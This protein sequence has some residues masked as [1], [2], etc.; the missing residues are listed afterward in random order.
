MTERPVSDA[1]FASLHELNARLAGLPNG[2]A[3]HLEG[4]YIG[5]D[6]L[7][8]FLPSQWGHP[9]VGTDSDFGWAEHRDNWIIER[10]RVREDG[11]ILLG[12]DPKTLI[13]PMP[14]DGLCDAM[15]GE[16]AARLRDWAA[17]PVGPDWLLPR[18]YQ[19]FEVETLSKPCRALVEPS[20]AWRADETEDASSL[21]EVVEF[22][23]WAAL[24]GE[25]TLARGGCPAPRH[26]LQFP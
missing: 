9:T 6:A 21:L 10:C 17:Q 5:R 2:Y 24:E 4:S 26:C 23:R 1:E 16:M 19:A 3:K 11:I 13:D 25:S 7:R 15:R 18:Y 20:Q 12:P 14:P 8:R 22:A